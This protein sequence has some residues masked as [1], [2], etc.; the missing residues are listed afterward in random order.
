MN[1]QAVIRRAITS[2][3]SKNGGTP[4]TGDDFNAVPMVTLMGLAAAVAAG[5][6]AYGVRRKNG[7]R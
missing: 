4:E 1:L 7:A 6:V 3:D 2:S 5:T